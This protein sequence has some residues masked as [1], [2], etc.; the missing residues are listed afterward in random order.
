MLTW[1]VM[2]LACLAA[3]WV[4]ALLVAADAGKDL[5][6]LLRFRRRPVLQVTVESGA[7]DGGAFATWSVRQRGRALDTRALAIAFHDRDFS[8]A[9]A[10]GTLRRG[11]QVYAVSG[12]GELWVSPPERARAAACADVD[13]FEAAYGPASTSA[14]FQRTV[15]VAAGPGTPLFVLA[16]PVGEALVSA[17]EPLVVATFDPRPQLTRQAAL[18][19]A[20]IAIEL[21]AG[22]LATF[23]ALR[24]PRFGTVS[25][26][27]AV[28]CLA[29]YLGVTPLAVGL[30]E[31]VRKPSEAYLRNV[32]VRPRAT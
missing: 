11:A 25:L 15:Q 2:G 30:R 5:A 19:A 28:L 7:G 20:F 23:V 16:K 13:R 18:V 22:G 9:I 1:T 32:W 17:G 31:R 27:G 3:L 26:G 10:G 4:T 29:F 8:S 14:G 24:P 6:A 12:P 21:A